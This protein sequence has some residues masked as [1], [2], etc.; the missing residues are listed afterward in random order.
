[1][2]GTGSRIDTLTLQLRN[3]MQLRTDRIFGCPAV[4]FA[5]AFGR[6]FVAGS[7]PELV[8]RSRIMQFRGRLLA[9]ARDKAREG[10]APSG[11]TDGVI[12]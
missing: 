11:L 10:T 2:C 12:T 8:P 1:M 5:H 3:A 7:G 9:T 4:K 6:Q